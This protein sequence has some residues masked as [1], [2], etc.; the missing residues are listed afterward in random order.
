MQT[1]STQPVV[2]ALAERR[3]THARAGTNDANWN[4]MRK[5][6]AG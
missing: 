3:L 5:V 1:W 4:E 6:C 2:L